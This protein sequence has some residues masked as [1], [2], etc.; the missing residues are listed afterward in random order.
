MKRLL[1]TT[2]VNKRADQDNRGLCTLESKMIYLKGDP[3]L[4]T[5]L[6]KFLQ[7]CG[8]EMKEAGPYYRHFR[9]YL[10]AW[11]PTMIDVAGDTP[12]GL[13]IRYPKSKRK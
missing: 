6:E 9:D 7:E 8:K 11:K 10:H 12:D 3:N 13:R 1:K 4:L 2:A 5:S